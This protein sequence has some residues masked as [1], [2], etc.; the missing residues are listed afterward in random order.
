MGTICILLGLIILLGSLFGGFQAAQAYNTTI[1]PTLT[2]AF[3]NVNPY[4]LCIGVCGCIG[5]L[6]CLNLVMH[7]ITLNRVNKLIRM[8]KRHDR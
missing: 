1:A 5:L 7:G 3:G 2:N 8:H 4:V 6:I